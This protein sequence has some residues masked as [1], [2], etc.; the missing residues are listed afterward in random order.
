PAQERGADAARAS[1]AAGRRGR[2]P[3]KPAGKDISLPRSRG[4]V[5]VGAR[6]TRPLPPHPPT[7]AATPFPH[8]GRPSPRP[9]RSHAM[10]RHALALALVAAIAAIACSSRPESVAE[11][12]PAPGY[13]QLDSIA[14]S[15]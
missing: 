1:E 11:A 13:A 14:V 5:G 15:G 2:T 3:A 8:R 6:S 4:R 7:G 9:P 10:H 12:P